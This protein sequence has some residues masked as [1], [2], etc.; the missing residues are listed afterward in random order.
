M[1]DCDLCSFMKNVYTVFNVGTN[2][3][4]FAELA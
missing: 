2:S 1:A 4:G 3:V